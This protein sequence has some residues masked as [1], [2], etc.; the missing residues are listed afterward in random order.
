MGNIT[1]RCFGELS[2]YSP[3]SCTTELNFE[4]NFRD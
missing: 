3:I 4:F 1:N 2:I